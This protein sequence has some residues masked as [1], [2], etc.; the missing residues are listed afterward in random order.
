[1]QD[2]DWNDLLLLD[3]PDVI[4]ESLYERIIRIVN[5][6][7]PFKKSK[8]TNS[9]PP[10]IT[11]ELMELAKDRD[12]FMTLAKRIPTEGIVQRAKALRNEAKSAFKRAKEEFVKSGLEEHQDNPKKFW[13]ELACVIPTGHQLNSNIILNDENGEVLSK[14]NTPNYVNDYFSTIGQKLSEDIGDLTDAQ[15]Q[16]I[17]KAMDQ[18]PQQLPGIEIVHFSL[19]DVI[20]L[21]AGTI[22]YDIMIVLRLVLYYS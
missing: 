13:Q 9:R 6:I 8:Y 10:W 21:I 16:T 15:K 12:Y 5:D 17:H 22:L 20:V 11:H 7:C 1:M 14:D 19:E 4:W 2:I 3:N 18:N